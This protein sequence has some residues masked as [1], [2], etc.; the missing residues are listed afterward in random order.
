MEGETLLAV[1]FRDDTESTKRY[2]EACNH[3]FDAVG[4]ITQS[5][6]YGI[7]SPI[8]E[9][10]LQAI[11][12]TQCRQS[13][14]QKRKRNDEHLPGTFLIHSLS[15]L[16]FQILIQQTMWASQ[17]ITFRIICPEMK[18]PTLLFTV[19]GL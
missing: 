16:H 1:P 10:E 12:A 3:I 13:I 6:T 19:K 8:A 17:N 14:G 15:Q 18:C 2:E 5:K 11:Q 7:A 9:K 4:E